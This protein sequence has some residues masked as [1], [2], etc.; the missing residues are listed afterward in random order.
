MARIISG[1][2]LMAWGVAILVSA[3]VRGSDGSGAYASGQKVAWIL[4]VVLVLLG[5]RAVVKGRQSRRGVP[6]RAGA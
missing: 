2:V 5:A 6:A 1:V 3:A 4:A